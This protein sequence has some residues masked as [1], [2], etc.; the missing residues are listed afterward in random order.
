MEE[1]NNF[2]NNQNSD[3]ESVSLSKEQPQQS[4]TAATGQQGTTPSFAQVVQNYQQ[5]GTNAGQQGG[6]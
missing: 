6:G 5:S 1:N 2:G 4:D 3:T